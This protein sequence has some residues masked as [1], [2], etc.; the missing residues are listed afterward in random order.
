[1]NAHMRL[2]LCLSLGLTGLGCG[3][4]ATPA[5]TGN[6][7]YEVRFYGTTPAPE[8]VKALEV[9]LRRFEVHVVP[10]IGA[11]ASDPADS[12]IDADG[13][14]TKA[15]LLLKVDVAKASS[16]SLA[17][18]AGQLTVPVGRINQIRVTFDATDPK[19]HTAT[20]TETCNLDVTAVTP[21]GVK[22]ATKFRP[23]PSRRDQANRIMLELDVAKSFTPDATTGCWKFTPVVNL[24]KAIVNGTEVPVAP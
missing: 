22:L 18:Q 3:E 24:A 17:A 19:N 1:M 6:S 23:L 13:L 5:P 12:S 20:T 15:D 16:E 7:T 21:T 10:E 11:T 8:G 2:A 9:T 14:W 4:E